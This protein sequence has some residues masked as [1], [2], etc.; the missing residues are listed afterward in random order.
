VDVV[1]ESRGSFAW[2]PVKRRVECLVRTRYWRSYSVV[3]SFFTSFFTVILLRR[4]FASFSVVALCR[5]S[6]TFV[7]VKGR[8]ERSGIGK[9]GGLD[10]IVCRCHRNCSW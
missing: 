1:T 2:F 4:S 5:R 8:V 7:V 6:F 9:R 3:K 10:R